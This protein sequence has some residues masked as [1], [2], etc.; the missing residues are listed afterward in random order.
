[1]PEPFAGPIPKADPFPRSNAKSAPEPVVIPD[2]LPD[3]AETIVSVVYVTAAKTFNGP[4]AGYTT[5]ALGSPLLNSPDQPA[6]TQSSS[7]P[8][9]QPTDILISSQLDQSST[10]PVSSSSSVGTTSTTTALTSSTPTPTPA[11]TSVSPASTSGNPLSQTSPSSG[12]SSAAK[13]GIVLAVLVGVGL[14]LAVILLFYRRKRKQSESYGKASDEGSSFATSGA[15]FSGHGRDSMRSS[16]ASRTAPQL[17]LRPVTQFLPNLDTKRKSAGNPLA[18]AT[19]GGAATRS[20][21][22]GQ[23]R[24][25][26]P[27]PSSGSSAWERKMTPS[28]TNDPA[29]PFGNHAE[30]SDRSMMANPATVDASAFPTPSN[31]VVVGAT[32]FAAAAA[33]AAAAGSV[34][35]AAAVRQNPPPPL[36]LNGRKAMSAS[37]ISLPLSETGTDSGRVSPASVSTPIA[38]TAAAA[39]AAAAGVGPSS[40]PVHRVQLDF[41]PSMSD[42]LG[43][44]AGQLVRLLHEYDDGWVGSFSV[45]R[46]LPPLT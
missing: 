26:S 24:Y 35:G 14:L 43:L 7:Q 1:M 34:T 28:P 46:C 40:C 16:E 17:S 42:E 33:A 27:S 25:V 44:R 21:L 11:Q 38:A 18:M 29:N 20:P 4:V 3:N 10:T 39:G 9:M 23:G 6:Q 19:A 12:L 30:A 41:K 5:I 2:P 8:S 22:A 36:D 13:A 31:G 32:G 37:Q 15:A 45:L